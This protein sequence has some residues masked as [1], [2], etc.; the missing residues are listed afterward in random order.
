MAVP[1]TAP[2]LLKGFVPAAT[3]LRRSK[4]STVIPV[5]S[6]HVNTT[7]SDTDFKMGGLENLDENGD[8]V[9]DKKYPKYAEISADDTGNLKGKRGSQVRI[10]KYLCTTIDSILTG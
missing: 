6:S 4:S 1:A 7:N 5:T 3:S 10:S 2:G 9:A 8:E